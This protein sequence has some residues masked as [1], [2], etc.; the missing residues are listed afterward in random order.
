M[1]MRPIA[2]SSTIVLLFALASIAHAQTTAPLGAGTAPAP[3]GASVPAATPAPAAPVV[4]GAAAPSGTD[5]QSIASLAWL[6]GCWTGTVNQRNFREQWSPV[7]GTMLLGASST[8]TQGNVQDFEFLRIEQR[9]D[10]VFYVAMPGGK[11]ETAFKLASI[12]TDQADAIYAFGNAAN[13]FPQEILYRRG[14]EGWL[15]ATIQG[16]LKGQE[17]KVIFPMRR[18]DCETDEL[19]RQ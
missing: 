5:I 1:T 4:T 9:P 6:H 7:R 15:Y 14:S 10:G 13:E 8:I 17:R 19:I 16:T 11:G 12:T 18:I 2:S 3:P